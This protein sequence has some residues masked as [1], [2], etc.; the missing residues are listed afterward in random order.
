MEVVTLE[1]FGEERFLQELKIFSEQN[2]NGDKRNRDWFSRIPQI[3]KKRFKEW[4]FLIDKDQLIAFATI[5][6][7]YPGC[8]RLLTRTYYNPI[9]RRKHLA[10]ER[11]YKTPAMY[12]LDSQLDYLKDYKTLFISMQ[13][14]SRRKVLTNVMNKI[15]SNWSLHPNMVQTCQEVNDANCWQ[16][17]IFT[18]DE[19]KLPS[20]T[21]DEWK[22]LKGNI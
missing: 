10:Y 2:F 17:V 21:I 7:F 11:N 1:K 20:I 15:N 12:L 19:I 3:Y 8:Y 18:G 4:F 16:N 5:Q 9:Y 13:D 22:I 6:E 14:I